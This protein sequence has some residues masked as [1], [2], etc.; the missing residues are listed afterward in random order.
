L[1]YNIQYH[2][3]AAIAAVVVIGL[4]W[5]DISGYAAWQKGTATTKGEIDEISETRQVR[6]VRYGFAVDGKGYTDEIY[7]RTGFVDGDTVQVTYA[8]SNPQVSTLQPER[9]ASI[10]R[11]SILISMAAALPLLIM[12]IAELV[13]AFRKK[14]RVAE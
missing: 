12:W 9:M 6:V 11:N 10:F 4:R 14:R 7:S 1:K 13:H 8:V 5:G 3:L 2:V